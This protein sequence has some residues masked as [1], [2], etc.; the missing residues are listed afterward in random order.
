[1]THIID[2]F[3]NVEPYDVEDEEIEQANEIAIEDLD[4]YEE[5]Y[6]IEQDDFKW[7]NSKEF[8]NNRAFI[9]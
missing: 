7:Y 6:D 3:D 1:M 8:T 4:E 9:S 5:F 2:Y